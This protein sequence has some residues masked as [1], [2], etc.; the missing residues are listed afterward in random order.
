MVFPCAPWTLEARLS[1]RFSAGILRLACLGRLSGINLR[2]QPNHSP[3]RFRMHRQRVDDVGP[4]LVVLV[5]VAHEA[6]RDS[7]AVSLVVDQDEADLV[8]FGSRDAGTTRRSS[9]M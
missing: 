3:P 4:A 1:W 8:A 5:A 9:I 6:R 7:V 2:E